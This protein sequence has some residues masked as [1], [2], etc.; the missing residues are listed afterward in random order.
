[1]NDVNIWAGAY[2]LDINKTYEEVYDKSKYALV[3]N[4]HLNNCFST[5]DYPLT[6]GFPKLF[7]GQRPIGIYAIFEEIKDSDKEK[8]KLATNYNVTIESP[9][10]G[11][12]SECCKDFLHKVDGAF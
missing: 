12:Y 8:C 6:Y 10:H 4:G 3:V 5:K 7:R 2:V 9:G 11:S 1:M